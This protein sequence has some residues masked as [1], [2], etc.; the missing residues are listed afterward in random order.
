MY[1]SAEEPTR[2]VRPTGDWTIIGGEGH[3][4][5]HDDRTTE[6]YEAVER[7][8][9][10]RFDVSSV[11]YRWSAQDYVT[12]DGVP[13]VGPISSGNDRVLVATGFRKWGMT[14]GTAAALILADVVAG[15]PN[16]WLPAFD[17]TRRAPRA[18]ITQ[19]VRDNLDVGKRLIG[20][21]L[22]SLRAR[23]AT[24]LSPGHGEV[25]DIEGAKVAAFRDDDGTLHTISARC[26]HLGCYITFNDAERTWDCP[27][28]G[29]RFDVQGRVLEGPAVEDLAPVE[30]RAAADADPGA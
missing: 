13:Y 9:R 22:G 15:R 6:R 1:I 12:V 19:L 24:E 10:D 5:G 25:A 23:P 4:T 11:D 17:S 21:R 3:K 29:S 2:S 30:P 18:S 14:N 27:C 8:A 28:H 16:E 7:W 20:D 26:T